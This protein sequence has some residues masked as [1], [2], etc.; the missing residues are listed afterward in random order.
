MKANYNTWKERK[1]FYHLIHF[2]LRWHP[3]RQQHCVR[4]KVMRVTHRSQ[5]LVLSGNQVC[6]RT[7]CCAG[8]NSSLVEVSRPQL[9]QCSNWLENFAHPLIAAELCSWES[10]A[11]F[12]ASLRVQH[13]VCELPLSSKV[14][15]TVSLS[16]TCPPCKFSWD[17]SYSGT[18]FGVISFQFILILILERRPAPWTWEN[19]VTPNRNP[20]VMS[21]PEGPFLPPGLSPYCG[22]FTTQW[23]CF[24][25]AI[26]YF[27]PHSLT[28]IYRSRSF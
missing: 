19:Q 17:S 14:T 22:A 6:A 2:L 11:K 12:P 21:H 23:T 28:K 16:E 24:R 7:R 25:S 3:S 15:P 1:P 27:T 8:Y 20:E 9:E 13:H 5:R 10:Q 4:G 26:A 18:L